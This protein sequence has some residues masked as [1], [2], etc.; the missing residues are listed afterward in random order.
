MFFKRIKTISSE[1]FLTTVLNARTK[2]YSSEMIKTVGI[3]FNYDQFEDYDFFRTLF[4]DLGLKDNQLRLIAFYQNENHQPNSW[5]A[6]YTT[7]DFDWLGHCKSAEV[8]DFVEQP[9][10]ALISFYKPNRYELKI[11][12]AM[13]KA[14]FKVGISNEDD[15]L[16]DLIIDVALKDQDTFKVELIKYLKTL[17]KI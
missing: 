5:D 10:D 13:S 4:T 9:F 8:A 17:K 14:K 3:L 15:R 11:V 16:H 7:L 1:K 2:Y 6:S 12:T